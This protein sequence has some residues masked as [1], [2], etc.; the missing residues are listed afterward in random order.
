MTA[1]GSQ[2]DKN[3]RSAVSV[4]SVVRDLHRKTH[5]RQV[6]RKCAFSQFCGIETPQFAFGDTSVGLGLCKGTLATA[7]PPCPS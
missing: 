3:Q 4:G 2:T 7:A 6:V 5:P 1:L